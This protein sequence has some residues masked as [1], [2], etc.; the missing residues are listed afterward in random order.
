MVGGKAVAKSH[1][2]QMD[3]HWM[4]NPHSK[5]FLVSRQNF[6]EKGFENSNAVRSESKP[7]NS[8]KSKKERVTVSRKASGFQPKG[9]I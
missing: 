8:S 6:F 9:G 4:A 2:A 7:G 1:E 3:H 5:G